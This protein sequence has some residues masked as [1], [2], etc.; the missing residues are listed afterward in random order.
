MASTSGRGARPGEEK[1]RQ[2]VERAVKKL[3]AAG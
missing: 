3:E 2:K 1:L